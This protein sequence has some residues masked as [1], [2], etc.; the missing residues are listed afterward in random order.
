MAPSYRPP[1]L[2]APPDGIGFAEEVA[3]HRLVDDRHERRALHIVGREVAPST[4]G[5]PVVSK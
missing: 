5:V 2:K 3:R 4:N 1:L